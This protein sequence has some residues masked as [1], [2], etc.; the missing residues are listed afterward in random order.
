MHKYI[1]GVVNFKNKIIGFVGGAEGAISTQTKVFTYLTYCGY[2]VVRGPIEGSTS[3]LSVL[4]NASLFVPLG[5]RRELGG[6][7]SNKCHSNVAC[8]F[9]MLFGSRRTNKL[10]LEK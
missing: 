6:T 7:D 5:C 9:I 10:V 1:R 2:S 4:M 3:G 8:G